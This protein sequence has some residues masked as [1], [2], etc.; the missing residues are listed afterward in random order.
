MYI[1]YNLCCEII[2]YSDNKE[3]AVCNLASIALPMYLRHP[4]LKGTV[5]IYS[6]KYCNY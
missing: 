1:P 4:S 5:K 6:K 3:Y 2:E